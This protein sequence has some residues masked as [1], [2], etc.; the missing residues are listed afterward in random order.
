MTAPGKASS[1]APKRIGIAADHGGFDLKEKL[2]A[3]F[4]G[5]ARHRRRLAKAARLER[6]D[7]N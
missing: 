1:T 5:A 6:E 7:G 2:S 4:T 3:R